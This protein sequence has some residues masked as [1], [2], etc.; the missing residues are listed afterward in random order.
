[1]IW[2]LHDEKRKTPFFP[3]VSPAGNQR[4]Q[5]RSILECPPGVPFSLI[6]D[7]AANPIRLEWCNHAF[8]QARGRTRRIANSRHA[9]DR[10]PSERI[11]CKGRMN[12]PSSLLRVFEPDCDLFPFRS[13]LKLVGRLV[14]VVLNRRLE[15]PKLKTSVSS[16]P[17]GYPR[18]RRQVERRITLPAPGHHP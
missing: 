7:C 5:K 13:G 16:H 14:V 11:E 12:S 3:A 2:Q 8:I 17:K 1:M 18:K 10:K 9:G 15:G 4:W 6:P